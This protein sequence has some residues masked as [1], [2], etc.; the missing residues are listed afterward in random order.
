MGHLNHCFYL[1]LFIIWG[2]VAQAQEYDPHHLF[3]KMKNGKRLQD[4]PLILS[5]Q[6]L[7]PHLYLVKTNQLE[8]L[9]LAASSWD[10]EYL[11]RDQIHQ[12]QTLPEAKIL[13]DQHLIK[14][15]PSYRLLRGAFNDE[16]LDRL[17]GFNGKWGMSVTEAYGQL[18]PWLPAEVIV[19][20][21]D[22]G[23]DYT[24]QDLK[25][26]MWRNPREIPGDGI[27]NDGNGYI[28][29]VYGINT[30]VRSRL[31]RRATGDP[32]GSHW[33]GTH[34]AGTIA[35]EQ[36]NGIGIAG[37]A[38]NVK[39]MAIRSVPDN[40][41]ELDSDIIESF[42]YAA[43][44]GAKIINCSFGKPN[45]NGYAVRDVINSLG[46][47]HGVLIVTASG[48]NSMG[49]FRWYNIDEKPF[50]P[51]AFDSENILTITSTNKHGDLSS[52]SNVGKISVD[53][54]APGSDIFSTVKGDRYSTSDGTS[55]AT[56]N[57][58]GVAAMVRGYFP[59]LTPVELKNILMK[60]AKPNKELE[61]MM[62]SAGVIN[63]KSALKAAEDYRQRRWR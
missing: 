50:Y 39:I 57:A 14:D 31:K 8:K 11:Q 52:F 1:A 18:P 9:E 3:I 33:H 51:A 59:E 27:D 4:S 2:S 26:I 55:M 20:V 22:T 36:N 47:D 34:V 62:R 54:A 53:V 46:R 25:N 6:E 7:I 58:A 12:R 21:V 15:I 42:L 48:N 19:A 16:Y 32:M 30:V 38:H 63:L 60:S 43:A 17:W 41:N 44:N 56:P 23:V 40:S 5:Q 49:P 24:H 29:D 10:I 28:D 13:P 61:G 35:A 37:V 45:Q